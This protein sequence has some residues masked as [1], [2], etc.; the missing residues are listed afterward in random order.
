[1]RR[2]EILEL[3]WGQIDFAGLGIL[4]DKAR[5]DNRLPKNDKIRQTPITHNC[6]DAL[7]IVRAESS[8]VLPQHLVFCHA[9][10]SH[11]SF[12]WWRKKFERAMKMAG[13]DKSGRGLVPHSLRH[14]LATILGEADYNPKKNRATMGWSGERVQDGYT[15]YDAMDHSRQR[16]IIERELS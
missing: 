1:M 13:L 16:E 15:H 2:G 7:R 9:D 10:G 6:A 4:V 8:W 3:T 14:T 11:I 12:D 5:T